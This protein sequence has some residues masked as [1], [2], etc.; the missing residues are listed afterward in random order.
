MMMK[1]WKKEILTI[2]NM[3][4]VFRILL[5]PVYTILYLNATKPVHYII[6]GIILA[7]SCLTDMVDGKIARKYNM[8]STLGKILDPVADKATHFTLIICLSI[9]YPVLWIIAG[10]FVLKEGFQL[11]AGILTLRKGKML[12]G[13]LLSGKICTVVLF[14][15]LLLFVLLPEV[16]AV[17]IFVVTG[18]DCISMLIA[19]GSYIYAY[20]RN[21]AIIQKL[22]RTN[23][24]Q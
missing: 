21:T 24:T 12:T 17:L 6:A 11:I 8:I 19:L 4:S 18:I 20:S 3:L 22:E 9:R 14:L 5:I 13:S 2:P 10:L 7:V 15:S 23:E 1:N 16:P